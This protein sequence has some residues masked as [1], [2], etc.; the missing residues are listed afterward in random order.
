MAYTLPTPTGSKIAFEDDVSIEEA[1]N[2][3]DKKGMEP[4]SLHRQKNL[5]VV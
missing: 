1:Q 2:Y 4:D 3:I 5:R